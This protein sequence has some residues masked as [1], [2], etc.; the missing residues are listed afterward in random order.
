[1]MSAINP[2][3]AKGF[4]GKESEIVENLKKLFL[5]VSAAAGRKLKLKLVDEQEIVMNLSDILGQTYI[6][7]SALLRVKKLALEGADKDE[8][9]AKKA[10][11]QLYIYEALAIAKKSAEDA[12]ASYATGAEKFVTQR[13]ADTLTLSY[14]VN[15]KDLRRKVAQA[16]IDK[17]QYPF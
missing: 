9:A 17:G 12:I 7:E 13:L 6:A 16:A 1:M 15:P 2:F 3:N 11:V 14:D 4:L 10:A 8:L 5:L